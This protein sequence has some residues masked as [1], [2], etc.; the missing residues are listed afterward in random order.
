MKLWVFTCLVLSLLRK[1]RKAKEGNPKGSIVPTV[2]KCSGYLK[3]P[4]NG[5]ISKLAM[6][7]KVVDFSR[8]KPKRRSEQD[9]LREL[10]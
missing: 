8:T 3:G 4:R 7:L 10:L 5:D 2:K 6:R 1:E 9:Q